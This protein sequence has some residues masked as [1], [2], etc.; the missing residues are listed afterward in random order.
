MKKADEILKEFKLMGAV[1]Q[2]QILQS[3]RVEFEGKGKLLE[4]VKTELSLAPIK[5]SCPHCSSDKVHKR[6]MQS[7]VQM[8]KCV[9]CTKWFSSTTGTPLWDIKKKDKWQSYLNCMQQNMS[10]KKIAKE[11]G[12]S[13]QT[14]FDWRH[15]I[16]SVLATHTPVTLSGR[17]ECDE[18]EMSISNKGERGLTRKPRKRSSDFKRNVESKEIMTVQVITA[19]DES[20]QKYLKVIETKRITAKHLSKT[21]GKKIDKNATLITDKHPS[22]IPFAKSK[23]TLT[24]KTV[25]ANEHVNKIDKKVNLQKVNNTHK[26]LR[27]FLLKF[28]GVSTKYLPNYLN[29]FAYGKN[30]EQAANQL[31]QWFYAI[32]SSETAYILYQSTKLNAVNIRT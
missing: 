1:A 6:G 8:F 27:K 19:V 2:E 18:L 25:K 30:M 20:N 15:K 16:L 7:G 31:K 28:N 13:I 9:S 32:V 26:E 5:K 29:W 14:S 23:P 17:V 10:I 4:V 22:Y 12:I 24:H 21:L 3:L 11:I